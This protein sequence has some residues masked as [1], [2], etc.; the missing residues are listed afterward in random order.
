MMYVDEVRA[1]AN[2][3]VKEEEEKRHHKAVEWVNNYAEPLIITNAK[4]GEYKLTIAVA[5]MPV[6]FHEVRTFL[7]KQGFT[8]DYNSKR[9]TVNIGW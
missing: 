5:K 3:A 1:I 4:Q 8:V 6:D 7:K 2:E 9:Q